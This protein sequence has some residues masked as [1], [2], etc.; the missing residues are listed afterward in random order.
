MS[1]NFL[2]YALTL[3]VIITLVC[4]TIAAVI[5]HSKGLDVGKSF[6]M[7]MNGVKGVMKVRNLPAQLPP[8]PAGMRAVKCPRCNAVQNMPQ[9]DETFRCWQC[10]TAT[11]VTG[12]ATT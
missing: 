2:V 12:S 1:G 7:G 10:S 6:L 9:A 11:R 5:G 8:A 3:L 4:G